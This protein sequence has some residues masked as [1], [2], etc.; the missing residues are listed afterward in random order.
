MK[1]GWVFRGIGLLFAVA[2]LQSE[3]LSAQRSIDYA[4]EDAGVKTIKEFNAKRLPV[5]RIAFVGLAADTE[6]LKPVFQ[7]G[8]MNNQGAFEFMTRD[9]NEWN[10][11]LNEIEF[12]ERKKDIMDPATIQKFGNKIKGADAYLYGKVLEAVMKDENNGIFRVSLTLAKVETGQIIWSGN[13][14]GEFTKAVTQAI[15]DPD[16][17]KAA[18]NAGK[19]LAQEL[20]RDIGKLPTSNVFILPLMGE[21]AELLSDPIISELA[22]PGN[23][24]L[25]IYST[26]NAVDRTTVKNI[27]SELAGMSAMS[28]EKAGEMTQ[29]LE[30]LYNVSG[31]AGKE[32]LYMICVLKSYSAVSGKTSVTVNASIRSL[33]DNQLLWGKTVDGELKKGTDSTIMENISGNTIIFSLLFWGAII[34]V[35]LILIFLAIRFFT[36]AR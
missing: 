7:G 14:V 18:V 1:Y 20:T 19:N 27:G 26:S 9:D 25:S 16:V 21:G 30:K 4:A 5:K 6:N 31:T 36:G 8:L 24:R 32:N 34:F 15:I 35:P 23:G 22:L 29:K 2:F 33:K 28:P 11:L 17:I 12:G 3:C 13:I 10:I